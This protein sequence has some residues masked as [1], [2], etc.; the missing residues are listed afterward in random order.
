MTERAGTSA[1]LAPA[2]S[3]IGSLREGETE[4]GDTHCQTSHPLLEGEGGFI[5]PCTTNPSTEPLLPLLSLA[6]HRR[7][8]LHA[9]LF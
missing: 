4:R 1:S 2:M 9:P 6:P 3:R 5:Q 7:A 8:H